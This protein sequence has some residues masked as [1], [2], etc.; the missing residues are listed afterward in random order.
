MLGA[1]ALIGMIYSCASVGRIEG[2]PYDETPPRF[3]GS[4]PNAGALNSTRKRVVL[5]FDE[6]IKLEKPNEK[7]VISPPQLQQPEIKP[8]GKKIT[9]NLLDTLKANTTYTIDFADAIVD[10]NEGNPL[11]SF[12]F[13][14]STGEAIDTMEIAGVVLEASNLEPI[15]GMLVGVHSNLE[16]SAFLKLPFERVSQTDSR[17]RYSIR[18][19]AP[20]TY[21]VYALMDGDRDYA[22]SQKTEAVAFYDSPVTP[23]FERRMRQD[24]TWIDS[25]TVDTIV[26]REYTH[27]LPDDVILRAFKEEASFQYLGKSERPEPHRISLSFSAKADTL[28]TLKGLNF[29]EKDAFV[30][31]HTSRN[32]TIH[33]WIKDS[34]IYKMDTL[35][36]SLDYLYTDTL[37]QLVPRTDTLK[38]AMRKARGAD[39]EKKKKKDKD[40]D[41]DEPEPTVFLKFKNQLAGQMDV[42][43][44]VILAFDEPIA[45][46]NQEA[47]HLME[48][49][50]TLF[51]EIPFTFEQDS[52]DIKRFIVYTEWEPEKE[53]RLVL[54]SI[55]FTGL[56]G[57]HTD[58][59]EQ[60]LN[61]RSLDEYVDGMFFNISGAGP[62]AF[63]ELLNEQ[64]KPLRFAPVVNGQADFYYLMPGKYSA[65]LINDRNGNG[66]WDTGDYE[67][68]IQPEEV[69]YFPQIIDAR[70]KWQ[71]D[72]LDWDVN[73]KPLD[74]QKVEEMKKQKPDEPKKK[75]EQNRNRNNNSSNR[76][77]TP[78]RIF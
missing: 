34:L 54:D 41:K 15:K 28:P 45:H 23:R 67:K 42:F 52:A 20:G 69:F 29:D 2:G 49:V 25:L 7:V 57:L 39:A 32:D 38:L 48:K 10:N 4:T 11:E 76:T 70:A 12:S 43:G 31:E 55:A 22:F 27:Y 78:P 53:Y 63:V 58:K 40:K 68:G 17:G 59:M 60:N 30:I 14:F 61:V 18:G 26:E 36:L 13:S 66:V 35:A 5:E 19:L 37:N 33:Y 1:S 56:Y 77:N 24:T 64:D 65:R 51:Q 72:D 71:Y 50:D 74:K 47:I 75:R 46:Y 16:D 6:F 44:S 21:R 62:N 73:G 8:G 3:I 9:I